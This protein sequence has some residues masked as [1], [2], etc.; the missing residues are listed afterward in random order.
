MKQ[1]IV[2]VDIET[3]SDN[4]E[5]ADP[6]QIAAIAADYET[7]EQIDGFEIKV[8]FIPDYAGNLEW[9][10][11][12]GHYD[13]K[14]WMDTSLNPKWAK[15]SLN[16]FFERHATWSKTP[17]SKKW[18]RVMGHNIIQWDAPILKRWFEKI[19][20]GKWSAAMFWTGGPV[21]TMQ[22]ARMAEFVRGETWEHG[23][24]LGVLCS[25]FGITIG[26]EHD[27]L[28]DCKMTLE[29]ARALRKLLLDRN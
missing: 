7:L 17:T 14:V 22:M 23:L 1:K 11:K 5:I 18:A 3:N 27:A 9:L 26:K 20:P 10:T 24:S 28:E 4:V 13:S 21:D 15:D 29:L 19:E 2:V 25:T 16:M 12:R 8:E 6:I